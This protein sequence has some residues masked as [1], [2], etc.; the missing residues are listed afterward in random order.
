MMWNARLGANP[1]LTLSGGV[2]KNL[3]PPVRTMV[4]LSGEEDNGGPVVND[5]K[6]MIPNGNSMRHCE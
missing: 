4:L 6:M 5:I 2:H 1:T 3:N